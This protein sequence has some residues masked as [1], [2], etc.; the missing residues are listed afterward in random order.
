[1]ILHTA[2]GRLG[3]PAVVCGAVVGEDEFEFRHEGR[4]MIVR[5]SFLT[6]KNAEIAKTKFTRVQILMELPPIIFF[7]FFAFFAANPLRF[8]NPNSR[9]F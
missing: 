8:H 6:A 4:G 7:V 9:L 3:L 1:M 2:A 5:T